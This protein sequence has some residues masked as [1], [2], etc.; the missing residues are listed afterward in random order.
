MYQ[1][2][3]KISLMLSAAHRPGSL[4]R[5]LSHI[6]VMGV[7]LTKLESRP[8]PGKDFEFRFF[9]DIEASIQDASVRALLE[10][11]R[12]DSEQFVF[13]GNYEEMR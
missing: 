11:L 3:N 2:A 12:Q 6:S 7:N 13:L 10:Q 5:L 4:Y 1:G 9:F 8:I